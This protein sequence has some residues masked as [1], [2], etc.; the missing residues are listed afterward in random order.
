MDRDILWTQSN[1]KNAEKSVGAKLYPNF[2]APKDS[3]WPKTNYS[4]LVQIQGSDEPSLDID[5]QTSLSEMKD[6][7][8]Q[9][10]KEVAIPVAQTEAVAAADTLGMDD[11]IKNLQDNLDL[12]EKKLQHKFEAPQNA[13][14][15]VSYEAYSKELETDIE[16]TQKSLSQSGQMSTVSNGEGSWVV[17]VTNVQIDQSI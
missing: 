13:K 7:E 9:M 2:V 8:K 1:L 3:P 14:E 12:A 15:G 6:A 17:P 11:D 4:G 16:E 10:K 5:I